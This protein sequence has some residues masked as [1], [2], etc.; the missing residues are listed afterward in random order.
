MG[1]AAE[2]GCPS[3]SEYEEVTGSPGDAPLLD[4]LLITDWDPDSD[5]TC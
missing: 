1:H 3:V 5:V 4:P 2:G